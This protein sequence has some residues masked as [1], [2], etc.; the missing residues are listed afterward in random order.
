MV[1]SN[2][3]TKKQGLI[4]LDLKN[5]HF[6]SALIPADQNVIHGLAADGGALTVLLDNLAAG[7]STQDILKSYPSLN[8][9][10][11]RAAIAYGAELTKE[12]VVSMP[13]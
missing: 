12:H 8:E 11:I 9:V 1:A 4:S 6:D 7:L 5:G 10:S 3:K 13:S 2:V